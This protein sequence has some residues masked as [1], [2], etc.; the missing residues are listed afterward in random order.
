MSPVDHSTWPWEHGVRC[1][2]CSVVLTPEIAEHAFEGS[3][4]NR[5]T[6]DWEPP[7]QGDVLITTYVCADCKHKRETP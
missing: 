5:P 4:D 3:T 2:D 7:D 1:A 6:A